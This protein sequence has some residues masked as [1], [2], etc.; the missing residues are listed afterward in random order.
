MQKTFEI[1]SHGVPFVVRIVSFGD[2]YGLA[3]SLVNND[4]EPLVE[5]YDAR[6]TNE[7]FTP[8]GQFVTRYRFN[9]LDHNALRNGLCMDGGI[10]D[11]HIEPNEM[12]E[13]KNWMSGFSNEYF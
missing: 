4:K 11:W 3:N 6:Y 1:V 5:F 8:F 7:K 9:V 12:Q 2:K 10:K 13:I